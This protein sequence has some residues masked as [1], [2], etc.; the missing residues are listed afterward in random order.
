MDYP[1]RLRMSRSLLN[2][3][4]TT[5]SSR[6]SEASIPSGK[7]EAYTR[8]DTSFYEIVVYEGKVSDFRICKMILFGSNPNKYS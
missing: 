5:M 8:M 6:S 7:C 1:R 3:L 4:P 2:F